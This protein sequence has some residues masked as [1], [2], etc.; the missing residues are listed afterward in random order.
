[1]SDKKTD[2]NCADIVR[3]ADKLFILTRNTQVLY[4]YSLTEKRMRLCGRVGTKLGQLFVS[5]ALCGKKIYIAPYEADFICVYNIEKGEFYRI[6]PGPACGELQKRH[7]QICFSYR[8]QVYLLG[9]SGSV[10]L[11]VDTSSDTVKEVPEWLYEFKSRYGYETAV[12]THTNVCI[13]NCCFWIALKGNNILLQYNMQTG[14]YSFWKIGKKR[15]QYATVSND[16]KY[17][18]LS[19][20]ERF[21]VR[22]KKESNE[23]KEFSDFPEG[24]ECCDEKIVW[25]DMFSCG[26]T[27]NENIYFA[28]LNSNMVVRIDLKTQRM[29]C[30]ALIGSANICPKIMKIDEK[31]LY[32]EE[33]DK[34]LRFKS[35]FVVDIEGKCSTKFIQLGKQ[36]EIDVNILKRDMETGVITEAHPLYLYLFWKAI[37]RPDEYEENA[38]QKSIG[39]NIIK[40]IIK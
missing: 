23:V 13:E 25:K 40:N 38:C 11:C 30:V 7:Y 4:E 28:P 14:E 22:W 26:Y 31:K 21:I 2:L 16:G 6:L 24:F 3:Y 9:G 8:N 15:I 39:K 36:D 34:G 27:W 1:M 20:D 18:W 33:D 17:F 12:A 35:S 10:M 29:E 19:G 32:I 5:M 37:A